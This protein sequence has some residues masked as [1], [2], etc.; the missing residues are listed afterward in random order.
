MDKE[1]NTIN[2]TGGMTITKS[3]KA[4]KRENSSSHSDL[5]PYNHYNLYFILERELFLQERGVYPLNDRGVNSH[6]TGVDYSGLC[7][8]H[9]PTRYSSLVLQHDW[10]VHKKKRRA[11]VKTHGLVSFSGMSA[12]IAARWKKEDEAITDFV[13]EIA[14]KVKRRLEERK[15]FFSRSYAPTSA[16]TMMLPD[17]T[18][19]ATA[20]SVTSTSATASANESAT[21]MMC[22]PVDDGCMRQENPT[23]ATFPCQQERLY[24][25]MKFL[26]GVSSNS[27]QDTSSLSSTIGELDVVSDEE[28]LAMWFSDDH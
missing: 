3:N 4:L 14:G 27:Q 7:L 17:A 13:T 19:S 24:N 11:H 26:N 20:Y 28:I 16:S 5:R 12:M 6:N 10:F 2:M 23:V 8:P 25:M 9:F 1:V 21:E 22:Y 15:L 18:V